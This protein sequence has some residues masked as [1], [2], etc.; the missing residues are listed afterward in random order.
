MA[1][2]HGPVRHAERLCIPAS[3]F[4]RFPDLLDHA[5][6]LTVPGVSIPVGSRLHTALLTSYPWAEIQHV[7]KTSTLGICGIPVLPLGSKYRI[8]CMICGY[9]E[10]ANRE[11][12][13]LTGCCGRR[14][15]VFGRCRRDEPP[16]LR[17]WF[18]VSQIG[19]YPCVS[20]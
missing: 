8:L 12:L 2:K 3:S 13:P 5:D 10:R 14:A 18:F 15:N 9:S 4:N 1:T 6:H 20:R 17:T 19:C 11:L 16:H 7:Y